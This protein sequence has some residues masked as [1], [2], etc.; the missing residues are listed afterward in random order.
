MKKLLC[1]LLLTLTSFSMYI[2]AQ[3]Y[4]YVTRS[5]DVL[6]SGPNTKSKRVVALQQYEVVRLLEPSSKEWIKCETVTNYET[7]VCNRVQSG[8]IKASHL[9]IL[10]ATPVS[11]PQ[12]LAGNT[13]DLMMPKKADFAGFINFDKNPTK[14]SKEILIN[15]FFR[16]YIPSWQREGGSGTT[17]VGEFTVGIDSEGA[18]RI[19]SA[20]FEYDNKTDPIFYDSKKKIL[21]FYNMVWKMA[22]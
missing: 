6:R 21:L 20:K 12:D 10:Q 17:E 5:K 2:Q 8:Y 13:F 3:N 19:A 7:D 14:D 4:A 16:F 9:T 18:L 22:R 1:F 11:N 15:A